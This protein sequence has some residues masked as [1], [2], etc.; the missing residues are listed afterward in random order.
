MRWLQRNGE[1]LADPFELLQQQVTALKVEL[2]KQPRFKRGQ[3]TSISPL[4]VKFDGSPP[5]SGEPDCY[6]P[7]SSLA[8]NDYVDVRLQG[9]RAIITSKIHNS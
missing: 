5:L 3:I 8:V 7:R 4:R 1:K 6:I 2:E 9:T